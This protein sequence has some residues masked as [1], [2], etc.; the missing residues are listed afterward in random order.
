MANLV[1]NIGWANATALVAVQWKQT[2][3]Q[4]QKTWESSIATAVSQLMVE[5]SQTTTCRCAGQT[6]L[7]SCRTEFRTEPR[8]KNRSP[9][10]RES[11]TNTTYWNLLT[12]HDPTHIACPVSVPL[13][14][15]SCNGSITSNK[16]WQMFRCNLQT[17]FTSYRLS[18]PSSVLRISSKSGT[19]HDCLI[20]YFKND[21]L[22]IFAL[23]VNLPHR[24]SL[25]FCSV[26]SAT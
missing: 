23:T 24:E 4:I 21:N 7:Q 12:N 5:R 11:A 19:L 6:A 13:C 15:D 14:L 10:S 26:L 22:Q 16:L 17:R 9:T 2:L 8:A 1:Y 25:E 18:R 20:I 3:T